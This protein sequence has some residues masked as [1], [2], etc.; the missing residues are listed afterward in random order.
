MKELG[1]LSLSENSEE[2]GEGDGN[3]SGDGVTGAVVWP[4]KSNNGND[5]NNNNKKIEKLIYHYPKDKPITE[6]NV[7][8]WGL[9]LYLGRVKSWFP[10]SSSSN[11]EGKKGEDGNGSGSGRDEVLRDLKNR[12]RVV[13]G[14]K[15]ATRKV[16][17]RTGSGS[18]PGVK[19]RVAGRDEL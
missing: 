16:M 1:L 17:K 6:S 15:K 13:K 2:S 10:P 5:D 12:V 19:I 18:I 7:K 14:G 9:D 8:Q 3:G 11:D 4:W